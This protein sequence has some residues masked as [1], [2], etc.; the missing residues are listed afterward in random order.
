[1]KRL[2]PILAVIGAALGAPA[3]AEARVVEL[4]ASASP[5]P[6]SCPDNC[7]AIG[8]VTGYQLRAGTERSPFKVDRRGKIVAFSVTLGNPDQEQVEFFNDLFGGPSQVQ[9]V[10]LRPGS[11]RRHRLT[12]RSEVFE[13]N[14]YFGSTP[15]FVLSRP[16]TVRRGYVVALSVPTW[17]PSFA[18]GLPES[19]VWRSSRDPGSCDDVR[20]HADQTRRGSLRTYGC[21]YRTAQLLYTA[22]FVPDN[23]RTN[24]R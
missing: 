6:V 11:K 4:G 8:R 18:V 14:D 10:I 17:I 16:V 9:L 13:V 12:G 2:L 15:T 3:A 1:M 7:Q 21:I 19:D 5:P 24:R 23:R 22:T 20:Q